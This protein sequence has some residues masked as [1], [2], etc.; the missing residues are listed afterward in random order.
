MLNGWGTGFFVGD[1]NADAEYLITNHHVISDFL[2]YGKGEYV[3]VWLTDG[4]AI[5]IKVKIR[6]YF[7]AT[8]YEEAYLIDYNETKDIALL[9]LASAT[10][11]RK[12]LPICSPTDDMI[13]STIYCVGYPGLSENSIID[14]SSNWSKTDVTV[15]TGTVSRFVTSSGSG[16]QRIQT[17]A[18]IQH[19]NSGGPMVNG[20]GSVIGINTMSISSESETS[21]YAVSIDEVIPMLNTN[22]VA[23]RTEDD[24]KKGGLS[25]ILSNKKWLIGIIAVVL[26]LAV[27]MVLILT[28]KKKKGNVQTAETENRGNT[29]SAGG[30][31]PTGNAAMMSPGG[32]GASN[33]TQMQPMAGAQLAAPMKKAFIRSLSAQHNGMSYPVDT[34]PILIGRDAA[35]CRIAYR[36]GT[37][38]VSGRH[39][40][41]SWKPDTEEFLITDLR[42]T[43]GTFLSNGQKLEPNVP[44][45]CRAGESFYVGEKTN[46]LRVEVR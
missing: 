9:R 32:T 25:G 8:N 17:D 34:A 6:V 45:R 36:E 15:T 29:T 1:P 24:M 11:E 18:V 30:M 46:M 3:D 10:D 43:Y 5:R 21:Y 23:Y 12:A 16:V 26:V 2:E 33:V 19:G 7:D 37:P 13:G 20:N 42:S 14:A 31:A 28:N 41:V 27:V 40:S 4:S 22:G 35:N 39:C 38:G 44:Y